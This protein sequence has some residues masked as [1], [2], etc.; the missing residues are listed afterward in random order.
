MESGQIAFSQLSLI[1]SI[2][3]STTKERLSHFMLLSIEH[4]LAEKIRNDF[5]GIKATKKRILMFFVFSFRKLSS[6]L[7]LGT[8]NI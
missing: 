5:S 7:S 1:K 8:H 3:R 2:L 4:Q 6:S